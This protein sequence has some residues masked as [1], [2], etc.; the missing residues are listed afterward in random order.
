ME[1]KPSR[2]ILWLT[3]QSGC[4]ESEHLNFSICALYAASD[5]LVPCRTGT[6]NMLYHHNNSVANNR[7]LRL[8]TNIMT[9]PVGENQRQQDQWRLPRRCVKRQWYELRHWRAPCLSQRDQQD[10]NDLGGKAACRLKSLFTTR[11]DSL[12]SDQR[13]W[14]ALLHKK[15]RKK[16]FLEVSTKQEPV[17]QPGHCKVTLD[18]N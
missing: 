7:L 18:R 17:L 14:F 2:A 9:S 4:D 16:T 5:I 6:L 1:Y 10:H 3:G 12:A 8:K 15:K 11:C 13:R